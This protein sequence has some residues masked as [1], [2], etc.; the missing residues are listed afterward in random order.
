MFIEQRNVSEEWIIT[1]D[2]DHSP[3]VECWIELGGEL[4]KIIPALMEKIDE[5]SIR[6]QFT[7]PYSGR[8]KLTGSKAWNAG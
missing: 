2:F 1:H 3:R 6:I 7:E 4:M 5:K 8:V